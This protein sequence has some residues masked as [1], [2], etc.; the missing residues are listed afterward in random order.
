MLPPTRSAEWHTKP[1]SSKRDAYSYRGA[2]QSG[3]TLLCL[4]WAHGYCFQLGGREKPSRDPQ[5]FRL[6]LD[7][8]AQLFYQCL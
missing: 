6:L 8:G 3:P 1:T 5:F 4:S 7:L 2:W